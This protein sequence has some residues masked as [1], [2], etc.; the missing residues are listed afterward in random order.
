MPGPQ[1]VRCISRVLC[2]DMCWVCGLVSFLSSQLSAPRPHVDINKNR[3]LAAKQQG[4]LQSQGVG[5]GLAERGLKVGRSEIL[6]L[7][8]V[9][10][11]QLSH[12]R[13]MDN[14]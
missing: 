10:G 2:L 6:Q 12:I 4:V 14:D 8:I 13:L 1:Q 9:T 11:T 3:Q 5:F 7:F